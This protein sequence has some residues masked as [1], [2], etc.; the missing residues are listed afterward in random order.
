MNFINDDVRIRRK[1]QKGPKELMQYTPDH[2]E[3]ADKMVHPTTFARATSIT[4]LPPIIDRHA[5]GVLPR[6]V[7]VEIEEI[8]TLSVSRRGNSPFA[9]ELSSGRIRQ[10]RGGPNI[11]EIIAPDNI[12][13]RKHR[14]PRSAFV[15]SQIRRFDRLL[16][17][18]DCLQAVQFR[19]R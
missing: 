16:D 15:V 12:N 8:G 6:G 17:A 1:R 5:P 4:L 11:V 9:V 13:H 2:C 19:A 14:S 3:V 18:C 10:M 7:A